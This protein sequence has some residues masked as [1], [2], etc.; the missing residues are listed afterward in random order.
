MKLSLLVLLLSAA[1]LARAA[2]PEEL[3]LAPY[4][5]PAA[6]DAKAW[7]REKVLGFMHELADFVE[8]NHTVTNPA[9]KTYGMVY[10]FWKGGKKMQEF[11]LD[12]MHD[13]AWFM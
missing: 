5:A 1:V 9:Q 8:K 10:E 12:A 2:S 6:P 7:P 4:K 13:G 11:G 3:A